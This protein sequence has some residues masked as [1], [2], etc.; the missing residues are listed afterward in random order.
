MYLRRAGIDGRSY[1][2]AP[3]QVSTV[4]TPPAHASKNIGV[5]KKQGEG[6]GRGGALS[7]QVINNS[8]A[9]QQE[10][11]GIRLSVYSGKLILAAMYLRRV[12]IDGRSYA[13]APTQ[14]SKVVT[15]PA[16]AAQNLGVGLRRPCSA[17]V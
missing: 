4:V 3:T 8:A 9:V 11:S 2:A 12:G 10:R 7:K 15:P 1:A 6:W 13:A 14:V 16:P 5:K 17:D